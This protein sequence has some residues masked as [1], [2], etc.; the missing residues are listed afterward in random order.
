MPFWSG[1]AKKAVIVEDDAFKEPDVLYQAPHSKGHLEDML[2]TSEMTFVKQTIAT[3][4]NVH[5]SKYRMGVG[6]IIA[7]DRT[8]TENY[9]ERDEELANERKLYRIELVGVICDAYLD[10]T[11]G[12]RISMLNDE[13]DSIYEV[14]QQQLDQSFRPGSEWCDLAI[15]LSRAKIQQELKIVS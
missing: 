14:C 10:V 9:W 2:Q 15:S 5:C 1:A 6:Y 8:M 7:A 3:F 13:A 11:R 12:I 4:R